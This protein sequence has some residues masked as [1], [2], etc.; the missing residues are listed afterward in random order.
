VKLYHA[1][2][3]GRAADPTGYKALGKVLKAKDMGAFQKKWEKWVG[4]LVF[5][6]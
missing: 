6:G 3:K 4:K 5:D 1:A 2:R